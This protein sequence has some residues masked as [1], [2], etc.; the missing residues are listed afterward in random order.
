MNKQVSVIIPTLNEEKYIGKCLSAL[1]KQDCDENFETIVV[2]SHST[3]RTKEI[4]REYDVKLLDSPRR[5]TGFQRNLGTRKSKGEICF[6]L[7]ADSIAPENW[8]NRFLKEY[9][10]NRR[11]VMVG[12]LCSFDENFY[13]AVYQPFKLARKLLSE[14]SIPLLSGSSTSILKDVFYKTGGYTEEA[15]ED[16]Y[17]CLKARKFGN[18]KL[19]SDVN[20]LTSSRGWKREYATFRNFVCNPIYAISQ[21]KINLREITNCK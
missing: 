10:K 9:E 8:I 7:D 15:C 11:T 18:V 19:V 2:D 13:S 12:S 4:A 17:L 5:N 3:D 1:E 6:Y 14:L 21:G 16:A 20:V